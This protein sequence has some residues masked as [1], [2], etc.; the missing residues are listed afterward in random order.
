MKIVLVLCLFSF[1]ISSFSPS[2]A[3][4][5]DERPFMQMD[6]NKDEKLSENEYMT[7]YMDRARKMAEFKFSKTD[8]NSDGELSQDEINEA[9]IKLKEAMEKR[10]HK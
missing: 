2:A 7:Y 9:L 4:N 8:K 1:F 6:T 5:A 10:R 3:Q